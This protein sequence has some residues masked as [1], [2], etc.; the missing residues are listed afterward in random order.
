[1]RFLREGKKAGKISR[2]YKTSFL[3]DGRRYLRGEVWLWSRAGRGGHQL[4]VL[5]SASHSSIK[6]PT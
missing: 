1:M 5:S 6:V 3:L 4:C 2:R